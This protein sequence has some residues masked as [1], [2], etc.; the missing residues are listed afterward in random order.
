MPDGI[1][2][3]DLANP[4]AQL[5]TDD[6]SDR[7]EREAQTVGGTP[8]VEVVQSVAGTWEGW[9]PPRAAWLE[10]P[11]GLLPAETENPALGTEPGSNVM[12]LVE[13]TGLEPATSTLRT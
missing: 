3:A 13:V 6:L 8:T 5:L 9:S 10:R 1:A 7:L 12:L 11:R 4:F 2:G